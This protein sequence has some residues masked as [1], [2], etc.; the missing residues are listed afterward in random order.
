MPETVGGFQHCKGGGS[1]PPRNVDKTAF[2]GGFSFVGRRSV[3]QEKSLD[4]Y[5]GFDS[6][7]LLS[8]F[9]LLCPVFHSFFSFFSIVPSAPHCWQNIMEVLQYCRWFVGIFWDA[10]TQKLR[11][12]HCPVVPDGFAAPG[13]SADSEGTAAVSCLD[14]SYFLPENL[15]LLPSQRVFPACLAYHGTKPYF[16]ANNSEYSESNRFYAISQE[17]KHELLQNCKKRS[18]PAERRNGKIQRRQ[19]Q[20]DHHPAKSAGTALTGSCA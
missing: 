9:S 2:L 10:S 8:V 16:K 12:S 4:F 6:F 19:G 1:N 17:K 14:S 20:S 5:N 7:L 13:A 18:E 3:R 15:P 11:S